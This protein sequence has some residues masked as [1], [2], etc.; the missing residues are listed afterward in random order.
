MKP[1]PRLELPAIEPANF[2]RVFP[3]PPPNLNFP[4]ITDF[5][6]TLEKVSPEVEFKAGIAP[7][8]TFR[9]KNKAQKSLVIYEWMMQEALN[10]SIYYI[11]WHVDDDIPPLEK[12][13]ELLP[14]TG[15]NPRRMTLELKPNNSAPITTSLSFVQGMRIVTP[16][17]F[18]ILAR[19]NLSSFPLQSRIMRVRVHP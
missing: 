14:D 16:Q 3:P 11:P 15:L 17:D 13:T 7:K 2:D 1:A 12:W 4:M 19:L 9:L 8:I 18:L 6:A 5:D 10:I